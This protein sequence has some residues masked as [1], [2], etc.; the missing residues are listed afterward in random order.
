MAD[1]NLKVEDVCS[2]ILTHPLLFYFFNRRICYIYVNSII[3]YMWLT[4][5]V[6]REKQI[7]N[8]LALYFSKDVYVLPNV[9]QLFKT[10]NELL[11]FC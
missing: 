10:L 7:K 6:M 4:T 1:Y 11:V 8:R 3:L 5:C 2:C 9:S